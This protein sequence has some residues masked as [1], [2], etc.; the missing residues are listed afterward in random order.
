MYGVLRMYAVRIIYEV[1]CT[2]KDGLYQYGVKLPSLLLYYCGVLDY[3]YTWYVFLFL[4]CVR[5]GLDLEFFWRCWVNVQKT[6]C[7]VLW[8]PS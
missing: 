8:S 6:V 4:L 1:R 7:R 5:S 2:R 3:S